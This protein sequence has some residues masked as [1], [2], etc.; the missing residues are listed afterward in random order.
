VVEIAYSLFTRRAESNGVKEIC[1]KYGCGIIAYTSV[2]RGFIDS[3]IYDI[4]TLNEIHTK[5]VTVLKNKYFSSLN[6]SPFEQSVGYYDEDL[7]RENLKVM[8]LFQKKA[9]EEAVKPATLALAWLCFSNII[10]IPGTTN[11]DYFSENIA[12]VSLAKNISLMKELTELFPAGCFNG[13]PNPKMLKH[14]DMSNINLPIEKT[15][16]NLGPKH[17]LVS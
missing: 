8:W 1:E 9:V 15:L 16:S 12:A 7:F 10:S 5:D 13:D 2:V 17:G 4:F 6:I 3:K 11:Q 14:L